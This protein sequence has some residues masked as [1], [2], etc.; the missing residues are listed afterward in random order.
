MLQPAINKVRIATAEIARFGLVGI[1]ATAVHF[2]VLTLAVE[3]F[4]IPPSTANGVAFLCALS[5]SYLGQSRWVFHIRS[6][7]GTVQVLRF[8]ISLGIGFL[9]NILVMAYSIRVLSLSYKV[10]FLISLIVVPLLSFFINKL[11][12]FKGHG[13]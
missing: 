1:I 3:R 6:R 5:I 4:S 10:G 7:H 12:V 9:A 13:N 8:S 11:W 2:S